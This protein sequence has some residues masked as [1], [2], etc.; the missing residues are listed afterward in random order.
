LE[1]LACGIILLSKRVC[2]PLLDS[3]VSLIS[4][5]VARFKYILSDGAAGSDYFGD[6]AAG[7]DCIYVLSD[8]SAIRDFKYVLGD[9]AAGS[10]V[11]MA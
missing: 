1:R 5:I 2:S 11:D 6:C 8:G 4:S 10:I 9:R 3:Q 7:S